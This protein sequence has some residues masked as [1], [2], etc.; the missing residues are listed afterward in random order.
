MTKEEK[1]REDELLKQEARQARKEEW[2]KIKS[3]G[4]G[5]RLQYLWDYYKHVVVILVLAAVGVHVVITAVKGARTQTLLYAC[6]VNAG[7]METGEEEML[8]DFKERIGGIDERRQLITFDTSLY[9]D[10]YSSRMT[11]QAVTASMKMTTLVHAGM[12]D[13]LIAPGDVTDYLQQSGY[14]LALDDILDEELIERL[15]EAGCL[16]YDDEPPQILTEMPE[17]ELPEEE[18]Q[19]G[20]RTASGAADTEPEGDG[21]TGDRKTVYAANTEPEEGQKIYAVRVDQTGILERY[22]L[23]DAG[24]AWF[25]MTGS[26]RHPDMAKQLLS[27]LLEEEN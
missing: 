6:L 1:K 5:A 17:E 11:Q 10:P 19:S 27:F 3:L 9:I 2:A 7:G 13:A 16:Y 20:D 24:D 21:E 22:G 26:V 15:T 14:L 8:A 18:Q 12:L 25:S 23:Y 4:P